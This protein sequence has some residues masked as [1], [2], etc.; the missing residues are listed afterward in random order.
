MVAIS[1][2]CSSAGRM[3]TAVRSEKGLSTPLWMFAAIRPARVI[4][5]GTHEGLLR[6]GAPGRL[7][8]R[9]PVRR[10][11]GLVLPEH[12]RPLGRASRVPGL[13][14]LEHPGPSDRLGAGQRHKAPRTAVSGIQEAG[15]GGCSEAAASRR[16][17]AKHKP[18]N[19]H[20]P[21]RVGM[22][23]GRPPPR[24]VGVSRGGAGKRA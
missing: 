21:G 9:Q 8:A 3:V 20:G 7:A 19:R 15:A 4:P 22:G 16:H 12:G 5:L 17:V 13:D 1:Q 2:S 18:P 14:V 6:V 24:L 23:G 10:A 11:R